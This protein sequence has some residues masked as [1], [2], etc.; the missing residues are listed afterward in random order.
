MM[1]TFIERL[2]IAV[3]PPHMR[4]WTLAMLIEAQ[5]L[6]GRARLGWYASAAKVALTLR[7]VHARCWIIAVGLAT[8]MIAV[9]WI[10]GDLLPALALIA[11]AAAL[12]TGA[13]AANDRL[14]PFVAGGTLPAAHA[15]AN[16]VPAIRP[17]YQYAPLN[18][19]DW[20]ML[21]AVAA[22]G[23]CAVRIAIALHGASAPAG[24]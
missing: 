22:I 7:L 24:R 12:L 6:E 19:M 8:T 18:V 2:V 23:F 16:W 13:S 17:H 20:A 3:T 11:L 14:A 5:S 10:W 21:F 4:H 15:I 1:R 9:D